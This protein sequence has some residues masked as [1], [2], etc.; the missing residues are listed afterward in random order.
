MT[1]ESGRSEML[2]LFHEK[3]ETPTWRILNTC[4]TPFSNVNKEEE[5][6]RERK[7]IYRFA[8]KPNLSVQNE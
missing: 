2:L 8:I 3:K 1:N 5:E 6:K 7:D 4:T